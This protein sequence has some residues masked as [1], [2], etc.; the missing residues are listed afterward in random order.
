MSTATMQ[1]QSISGIITQVRLTQ[2]EVPPPLVGASV[3]VVDDQV[4]VFA[5]RLVS[6]RKMTNHL[7][8]LDLN[9]LLWTRHFPSPDSD[10]PPQARYFHS[11]SAHGNSIVFFG[12][13][14]HSSATEKISVLNDVSLFDLSTMSWKTPS[15]QSSSY[16]PSARYAH[17][18][19]VTDDRLV[20]VGGQDISNKYIGEINVLSLKRWEWVQAKAFDKPIGA[21]RSVA[22]TTPTG[23]RLPVLLREP[24]SD[25]E[26]HSQQDKDQP[27]VDYNHR[28]SLVRQYGQSLQ[29]TR[30]P[31]PIYLYSNHSFADVRRELQLIFLPNTTASSIEDCSSFMSGTMMPPGLR[32]PTGHTLGHHLILAGTYLSPQSQAYTIW[33]LNLGT[34]T[35]ARIETGAM[36]STG[37]WHRGVLH[38]NTNRFLVFGNRTRSFLEDYTHRQMNF[39]HLATV[40]LEAFGV[41]RLPRTTCS[42]LAQEMGLSL[43]NEPAVAD[44]HIITREQQTI[45]VNSAV[46]AQ[47]WPYFAELLQTSH[48][49]LEMIDFPDTSGTKC[50]G[51]AFPYPYTV[52]LALLQFIYTDNLLTAQQ[53]QPHIL[54][55]LLLLADMYNLPRLREL[56]AHALHQMLNMS[57]AP[58][59]FE[60]A[61]L[62]HQTSL[63]IRALKMMIAAKKMIQQQQSHSETHSRPRTHS[64][65]SP[66]LSEFPLS[67]TTPTHRPS[68]TSLPSPALSPTQPA[69]DTAY[70]TRAHSISQ[71]SLPNQ[72]ARASVMPF[73]L[74]ITHT[75]TA[76]V[77]E[78]DSPPR[79]AGSS[80]NIPSPQHSP[81]V[82]PP[83]VTVA[84]NTNATNATNATNGP[85]CASSPTIGPS[86][87]ISTSLNTSVSTGTS[88]ATRSAT[89]PANTNTAKSKKKES[90]IRPFLGAFSNKLSMFQ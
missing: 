37:S 35:W 86:A 69:F 81:I 17:L 84:P 74:G 65:S 52:V 21:Y 34:L 73:N 3:T 42:S 20:I 61:A 40:D 53:Y 36:F 59:I 90:R 26:D 28:A 32:F 70:A 41:Y 16:C 68:S 67:P 15:L 25:S 87:S 7:Y 49:G 1:M 12:G 44:F 63:Q 13:M 64:H 11:A 47:R 78:Q 62:S 5:G 85:N 82:H 71:K 51:M 54:S 29:S 18:S 23:T 72:T 39:D 10:P 43:L 2:G 88:R 83:A 77:Y 60:T 50:R 80:Y 31:S 45:P 46:L 27:A 66:M 22:I 6:S 38:E 48:D 8:I 33:S 19:S 57:T 30:E 9:T 4:F 76:V 89:A 79:S 14:G 56:A 24:M 58:L 55:Q 75:N